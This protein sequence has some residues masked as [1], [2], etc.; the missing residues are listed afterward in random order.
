[1]QVAP[2]PGYTFFPE[3]LIARV[4]PFNAAGTVQFIDGT[5]PLGGPVPVFAGF[6]LTVTTLP[7]GTHSLTAVFTPTDPAAFA[8][9]TSSPVP[10]TVNPLASRV[11][12]R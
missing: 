10:L 9:S 6:A 1:L 2:S 5:T 8:Q 4:S 7:K 12:L 3:F 11:P